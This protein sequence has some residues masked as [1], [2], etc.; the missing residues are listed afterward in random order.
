[1]ST[2][3]TEIRNWLET[4]KQNGATHLLVLCDA[5]DWEDYPVE[6]KKGEN[7]QKICDKKC[8]HNNMQKLME[9][10]DLSLN[11]EEQLDEKRARHW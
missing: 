5:F 8:A 3:K 1:M 7:P 10:Y 9:C 11:I 6:I 2:T 4:A